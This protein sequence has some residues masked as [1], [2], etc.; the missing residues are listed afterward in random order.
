MG[1]E[2]CNFFCGII[3]FKSLVMEDYRSSF[4]GLCIAY[5]VL[6]GLIG[7][8]RETCVIARFRSEKWQIEG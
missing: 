6:L 3:L 7:D 4:S 2:G 5:A 8:D 1:W